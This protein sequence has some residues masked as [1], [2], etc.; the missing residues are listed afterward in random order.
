[1]LF[2]LRTA[3]TVTTWTISLP[4]LPQRVGHE[5]S[6][7]SPRSGVRSLPRPEGSAPS[8]RLLVQATRCARRAPE[9][10]RHAEPP[11]LFEGGMSASCARP[12]RRR[13]LNRCVAR[14]G[15][16]HCV[17]GESGVQGEEDARLAQGHERLGD[18]EGRRASSQPPENPARSNP[19]RRYG[20]PRMT[21]QMSSL[22]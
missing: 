16:T 20:S 6:H 18:V 21:R 11:A 3:N 7:C 10:E 19:W 14:R 8:G 4:H 1:M 22:R 5:R 2:R 9:N 17:C 15:V 12:D 13:S